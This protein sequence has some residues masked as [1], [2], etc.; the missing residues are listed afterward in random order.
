M[1]TENKLIVFWNTQEAN[2]K[3]INLTEA[4][5]AIQRQAEIDVATARNNVEEAKESL[6]KIKIEAQKDKNFKA[7]AEAS[8]SV[9]IANKRYEEY[10][11]TYKE[12]FGE[13][14]KLLS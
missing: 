2:E 8:L 13:E 10:L 5:L 9:K 1:T 11:E 7:I 14:P 4:A 3:D 12:L 6:R